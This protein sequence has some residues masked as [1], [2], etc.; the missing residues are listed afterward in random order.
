VN[1]SLEPHEGL[2]GPLRN[3][4]RFFKTF[5]DSKMKAKLAHTTELI[6]VSPHQTMLDTELWQ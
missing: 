6:L 5:T 1:N 3:K 4:V 2:Y